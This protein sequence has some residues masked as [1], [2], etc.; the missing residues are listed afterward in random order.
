MTADQL[1]QA[2]AAYRAAFAASERL[3]VERRT[4]IRAALAAGWTQRQIADA[5]GLSMQR[6]AQI[7]PRRGR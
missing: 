1:Q 5:T 4:A 7:A 3:R 2:E 6:V